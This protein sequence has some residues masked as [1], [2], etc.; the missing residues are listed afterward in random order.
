MILILGLVNIAGFVLCYLD[1]QRA[2]HHES[3]I[4]EAIFFFLGFIGGAFLILLG[5][6]LFHHK[7]KKRFFT[8]VIYFDLFV[9]LILCYEI[10]VSR[11]G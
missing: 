3:R 5:M 2:I 7:T 9:S 8:L 4:P 1:K 10:F 6:H 11:I